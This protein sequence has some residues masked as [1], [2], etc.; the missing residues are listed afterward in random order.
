MRANQ[1]I[2]DCLIE[3]VTAAGRLV[4]RWRASDHV[5]VAE[6]IHPYPI[7]VDR[8]PAYDVF[9][10]NSIDQEPSTGDLLLSAHN[11]DAV[12]R[13]R[14]STGTI[15]WKL[16]GNSV[17][18]D[19][20]QRLTVRKDPEGAFHGQHD[21]RFQPDGDISLF[22]NHTWY[23]G[24]A[25]GV[26]YHLD[27]GAGTASLVWQYRSADAGHSNAT[28]AF[29]RYDTGNDNLVTWGF[30]PNSLF[31][32]VDAA[33]DV[34]MNVA[35][36]DGDAAYRTIKTPLSGFDADLLHRTAGLPAASFPP[37]PRLH[38]LGVETAG[39]S[40]RST[41]TITGS[42]F[43]GATSVRFGSAGAASFSVASDSSI[44]ATA[45][46]G[47]GAVGVTVTTPGGTSKT[48]PPNM[49]A[50]SDGDFHDGHRLVEAERQRHGR[51]LE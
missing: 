16:G 9:H 21:A 47:S 49:L 7:T 28:G 27:T 38:S 5:S 26:E 19:G 6:S 42:G 41:V 36:P 50:G 18:H 1:T 10:C 22:D 2:V 33:G 45:P 51:A 14:G 39:R 29:R 3:E 15:V 40:D 37:L 44:T 30:K 48:S 25:R 12:Y 17:V 23:L 20:E 43:T 31:T 32:E 35:F 11:A 8:Q 46:P 24:A 13:I 4:W 34:L